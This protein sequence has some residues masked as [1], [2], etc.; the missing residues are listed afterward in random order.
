MAGDVRLAG[1]AKPGL[2]RAF[3]FAA[4]EVVPDAAD[5]N[6]ASPPTRPAWFDVLL[7]GVDRAFV[8]TG[9]DTPG[10]P[11]PHPDRNPPEEEYSRVSDPG[12]YRILDARVDAWVQVLAEAGVAATHQ[13]P[14]QSWIAAPRPPAELRRVRQVTPVRPGGLTL[15]FA[16][17]LVD[18]TPFGLDVATV[19]GGGRPVFLD[20]VP[21]CGCDACDSGSADL[22]GTLDGWVLRVARGGVLHARSGQSYVTRTLDGWAS[23]GG[24]RVS[25][26]DES[27]AIPDGV[28][29]WVGVPW[30]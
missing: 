11:D 4:P 23:A 18:G 6:D 30:R 17:T 14:A 2:R 1:A 3:S 5:M 22:L 12:K 27:S 19:S 8:V 20:P 21:D 9:A 25:W 16:T 29:R 26:L 7:A 10:W 24:G 15:L 28:E 13:V